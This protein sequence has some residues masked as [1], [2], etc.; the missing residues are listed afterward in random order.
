MNYASL[1]EEL[2][3]ISPIL[4][5]LQEIF[6]KYSFDTGIAGGAIRDAFLGVQSNDIDIYYIGPLTKVFEKVL[7]SEGITFTEVET[8]GNY[9]G[10]SFNVTHEGFYKGRKLQFIKCKSSGSRNELI[11]NFPFTVGRFVLYWHQLTGDALALSDHENAMDLQLITLYNDGK[12]E[13]YLEKLKEK[14]IP[15]EEEGWTIEILNIPQNPIAIPKALLQSADALNDA[16]TTPGP[17]DGAAYWLPPK[18]PKLSA[19]VVYKVLNSPDL[20]KPCY[21]EKADA[22][23]DF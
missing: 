9:A 1:K 2:K 11:K 3:E 13:N 17:S 16:L 8:P 10:T 14:F 21:R 6:K 23:I 22:S 18:K 5:E 20:S 7:V 4:F 12:N 15:L 19:K